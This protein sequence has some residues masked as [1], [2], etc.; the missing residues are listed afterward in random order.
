MSRKRNRR[1]KRNASSRNQNKQERMAAQGRHEGNSAATT[2]LAGAVQQTEQA[3]AV[4]ALDPLAPVIVRSGRPFDDQA[5]LDPARFPPPSTVAG[6]LRTAWARQEGQ[7]FGLHLRELAVSGPL[8]L[9]RRG[10]ALVPKPADAHY[11]GAGDEAPARV[12]PRRFEAGC[13]ADLPEGLVPVQLAKEQEGKPVTGPAWWSLR[14]FLEFRRGKDIPLADL[15][16]RGWSPTGERRT[17]VAINRERGAADEGKLFQTEGLVLDGDKSGDAAQCGLRLLARC[18]EELRA[19]LV[20]LG[21]ERRLAALEPQAGST[22]PT[23]PDGWLRS[24]AAAGGV[25]LTLLTPAIFSTGFRPGW[26]DEALIGSPP[27]ALSLTLQ[28]RAVAIDRWQ[29]HSG[30]DLAARR[31]RPTRK[32]APAGATYWFRIVDGAD[33][34]ALGHLW[35]ANVSD[36]EQDRRD[37]FGLALPSAWHP[38]VDIEERH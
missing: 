29:P 30:W 21:G 23:P 7:D 28:L 16:K 20:H 13:S 6:C 3:S 38:P 9:D 25:C 24:V 33:E 8:L 18:G 27:A 34:K 10:Q 14:D 11:F 15:K 5:G 22:W 19:G 1:S 37:G 32:L 17:H 35:L 4:V 36:E 31:P 2:P 26:L 12:E